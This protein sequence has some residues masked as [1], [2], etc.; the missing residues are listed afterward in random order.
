MDEQTRA[1]ADEC[2][3]QE[4]SCL[5]TST[6]LYEWHKCLRWQRIVLVVAPIVL[7][8]IAG[9]QALAQSA[10]FKWVA[11]LLALLAGMFPAIYKALDLDKDLNNVV[12][13]ASRFKSLQDRF[14]QCG[15][16]TVQDGLNA[17]KAEFAKLMDSMD[18]VRATSPTAPDRYFKKADAKIKSGHYTFA[19]DDPA[20]KP[21]TRPGSG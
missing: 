14:R 13:H 21:S 12:S 6:A 3:R 5:W 9:W 1:L 20:Q 19:V 7:G 10:E 8:G 4:E 18:A 2:K 17:T 15:Q 11:G 16:I